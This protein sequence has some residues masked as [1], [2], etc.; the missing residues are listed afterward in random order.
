VP[1][2]AVI[3]KTTPVIS[4]VSAVMTDIRSLTRGIGSVMSLLIGMMWL[5][6]V[7]L[8]GTKREL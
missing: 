7:D 1:H 3:T 2:D 4:V 8:S 5:S 6:K